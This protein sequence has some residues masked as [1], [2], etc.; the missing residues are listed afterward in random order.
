M[1]KY[2]FLDFNGTVLDD[3]ELCFNI[4]NEMLERRNK[5]KV[6]MERYKDIFTF[7]I[8]EYYKL[9]GLEFETESF[10]DMAIEFI[11]QYQSRSLIECNIYND[12]FDTMNKLKNMGIKVILC[13]AS[14]YSNLIEQTNHFKIT[15]L[16]DDII[17][18]DDIH[19]VSKK[20]LALNFIVR[21]NVDYRDVLFVGDTDHDLEVAEFCNCDAVLVASGH[22]NI[23]V[24]KKVTNKCCNRLSD[25]FIFLK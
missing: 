4:L 7:P 20:E 6:T 3:V 15:E 13:S 2:V 12:F 24:L 21:H 19:A 22:Q 25:I 17:G 5:A 9:A 23:D 1:K 18:L 10:A 8:I 16:F 14:K 11:N